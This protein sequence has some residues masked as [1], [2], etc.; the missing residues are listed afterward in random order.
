MPKTLVLSY[1]HVRFASGQDLLVKT[2]VSVN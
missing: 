2:I 1:K